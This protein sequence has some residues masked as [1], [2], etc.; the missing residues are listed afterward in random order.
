MNW[1][2]ALFLPPLILTL[3]CSR[4]PNVMTANQGAA[5]NQRL[6]FEAAPGKGGVSPTGSLA[7]LT[8]QPGTPLN[9]RMQS[10]VSSATSHAGDSFDA[11]VDEPVIVEGQTVVPR[12]TK[13]TGKVVAAKAS[14]GPQDA[15]YLRLM[16]TD[17]SIGG[18]P[19]TLQTSSV[20]AKGSLRDGPG[21]ELV[22]TATG[23]TGG[24]RDVSFPA[25]RR[26]A[27]RLTEPLALSDSVQ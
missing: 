4:Q 12:G 9:V 21:S 3:A 24:R 26:V 7:E 20:F 14:T 25:Q 5:N 23:H 1:Q 15:G 18:K 16:L 27:F 22:D 11:V 6:S 8:L 17:I 19:L 2:R 10:A 13:T